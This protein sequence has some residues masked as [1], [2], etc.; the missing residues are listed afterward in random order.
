MKKG[1]EIFSAFMFI[2]EEVDLPK[3]HT[4]IAEGVWGKSFPGGTGGALRPEASTLQHVAVQDVVP[5]TS[6][7]VSTKK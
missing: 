4:A 1:G 2:M 6:P 3:S 7:V 5:L